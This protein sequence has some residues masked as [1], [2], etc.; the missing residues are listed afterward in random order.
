MSIGDGKMSK[1]ATYRFSEQMDNWLE[2]QAEF[3]GCSKNEILR[4][5]IYEKMKETCEEKLATNRH[6]A[7]T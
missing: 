5:L 2:G 1:K 6:K 3:K 4:D 7:S